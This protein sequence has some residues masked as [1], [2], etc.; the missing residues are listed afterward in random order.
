MRSSIIPKEDRLEEEGSSKVDFTLILPTASL[1]YKSGA[2]QHVPVPLK[3]QS[4]RKRV[5]RSFPAVC[6]GSRLEK[7]PFEL[8]PFSKESL[9]KQSTHDT[10]C[11][12]TTI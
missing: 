8:L 12:N 3:L 10:D 6:T 2:M 9:A 4:K 1:F 5:H 7:L 11:D